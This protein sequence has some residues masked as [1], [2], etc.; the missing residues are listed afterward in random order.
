MQENFTL[1]KNNISFR[2]ALQF[3]VSQNTN[4]LI[5]DYLQFFYEKNIFRTENLD[6]K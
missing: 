5:T 2:K 6:S 4:Y 3:S 1:H